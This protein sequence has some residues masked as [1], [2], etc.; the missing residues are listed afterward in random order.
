M[1]AGVEGP[2]EEIDTEGEGDGEA[3]EGDEEEGGEEVFDGFGVA[4]P[5]WV[6]HVGPGFGGHV[7]WSLDF[8]LDCSCC[9]FEW[10]LCSGVVFRA[11]AVR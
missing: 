6:G 4:A 7:G 10:I 11:N 3:G 9:S 8:F 5:G 2:A 1:D